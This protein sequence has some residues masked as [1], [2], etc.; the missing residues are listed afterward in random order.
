MSNQE[1]DFG[2]DAAVPD[3]IGESLH[4]PVLSVFEESHPRTGKALLAVDEVGETAVTCLGKGIERVAS[5]AAEHPVFTAT[6]ATTVIVTTLG[7]S[8][9]IFSSK[10]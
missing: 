4:N 3:A 5:F 7:A 6:A 1:L 9:K 2:M 8:H 10:V